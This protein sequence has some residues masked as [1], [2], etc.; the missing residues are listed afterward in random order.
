MG[1]VK[2]I[3]IL[4]RT[5]QLSIT[6]INSVL[7]RF[8][9][10][11]I[12]L[13]TSIEVYIIESDPVDVE[14]LNKTLGGTVK[15]GTV[16]TVANREQLTEVISI[17]LL[18]EK[19][20]ADYKGKL[21]FGIS[22]YD[23]GDRNTSDNLYS[24]INVISKGI[25]ALLEEKDISSRFAFSKERNLSSVT[26]D[27]NKLIKKGAEILFVASP[28][29]V[30]IGKTLCVQ[31]YEAFSKR[32]YGRPVRDMKSGV[33][34]PK[35]ARM[36]INL[37]GVQKEE[38]LLD[39]FCGSGTILQEAIL[40]GYKNIFGRDGSEKAVKDSLENLS[41][42]KEKNDF[43]AKLSIKQFDVRKISDDVLENSVSAVI[44]EPYLG[45]TLHGEIFS[46][47]L[48]STRYELR[49]LYL[50]AFSE[51]KK[52]LKKGGVVVMVFPVFTQK[53]YLNYMEILEE[54]K[55]IGFNQ[56]RLSDEKRG[57][58]LVGGRHDFVIREVV[59]F[60]KI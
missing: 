35:L 50:S 51:F 26:V 17:D 46:E 23:G 32:D 59:M 40:L 55:K 39:P 38:T 8:N 9:L 3:F 60:Q 29:G 44:T 36:M 25:K 13:I 42:L 18:L 6:E 37:A 47:K 12:P 5:P 27:K 21:Q 48:R 53:D 7:K 24:Q 4:G 56:L 43:H 10:S 19:V 15:I 20:F 34:P 30:Y 57:T 31:E 54:V 41:W 58:I 11:F 45:P 2:Y 16:I 28:D 1:K 49:N 14:V 33:M 22:I 52:I